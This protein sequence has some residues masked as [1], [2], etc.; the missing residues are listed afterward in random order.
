VS[1]RVAVIVGVVIAVL[2]VAVLALGG[3]DGQGDASA[4]QD[5]DSGLIGRLR[6]R[7]GDPA[8]VDLED[9]SADCFSDDDPTL[10]DFTSGCPLQVTNDGGGIR[11]LRLTSAQN[12]NVQ[13]PAP[14]GDADIDGDFDPNEEATVAVG[15]GTTEVDLSCG[16]L[17]QCFVRVLVS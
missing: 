15:E 13:A 3:G 17:T 12:L 10:L 2:F 16:F 8:S 9:I 14:E 5:N 1:L 11:I 4:E 6:D 7:A